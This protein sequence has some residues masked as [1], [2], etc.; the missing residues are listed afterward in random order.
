MQR[1]PGGTVQVI[2]TY[3]LSEDR[4]PTAGETG[5]GFG[6]VKNVDK[7]AAGRLWFARAVITLRGG[8]LQSLVEESV[9]AP[10][11]AAAAD[12]WSVGVDDLRKVGVQPGLAFPEPPTDAQS[13]CG[14]Y[15]PNPNLHP[16]CKR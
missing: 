5:P 10:T 4:I 3:A 16:S 7:V 15:L 9:K 14:W 1:G 12:Q 8:D 6:A 13:G 2:R 11:A